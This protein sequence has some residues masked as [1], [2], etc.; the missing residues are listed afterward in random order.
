MEFPKKTKHLVTISPWPAPLPLQNAILSIYC[1]FGISKRTQ[2]S[3]VSLVGRLFGH[4]H[5]SD[6]RESIRANRFAKRVF[7]KHFQ[8]PLLPLFLMG[9]FP[10]DFQ[11]GKL[12]TKPFGKTTHQGRKTA[13]QGAET[14]INA[15]GQF[16]GTHPCWKIAPLKRP[17]KRSMTLGQ[18]RTNRV[19]SPIRIDIRVIRILSS[20]LPIFWKVDS[21]KRAFSRSENR[22]ARIG[23]LST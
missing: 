14:P 7:L 19:F 22:F 2:H 8:E 1:C 3:Y 21:Q 13:H 15:N 10:G 18:I 4:Q 17:I 12:P 23:P 20:Q 9:C 6:S 16:V 5:F 11:E